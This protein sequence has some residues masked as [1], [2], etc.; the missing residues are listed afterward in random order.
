MLKIWEKDLE[1]QREFCTFA[2]WKQ[3]IIIMGTSETTKTGNNKMQDLR[4][5][6]TKKE[7]KKP[8]K[9]T[10]V[11]KEELEKLRIPVYPYLIWWIKIVILLPLSIVLGTVD[12]GFYM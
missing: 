3:I 10:V 11:S 9:L 5:T 2:E 12:R 6:E 4:E 1:K 8:F 7:V